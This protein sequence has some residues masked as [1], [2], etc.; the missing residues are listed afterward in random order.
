MIKTVFIGTVESSY[1]ALEEMIKKD[2][3]IEAVFTKKNNSFNSDHRSLEPLA[4]KNDIKTYFIDNINDKI[5]IKILKKIEPDF[6]FVIG[7]SQII[8][9][10]ILEIPKYGCIGFH[11]SLLPKNRGRAVIPWAILSEWEKTGVTLFYLDA[12]MDSGDIII[13]KEI[14]IDERET[15]STLYEKVIDSLKCLIKNNINK[16]LNNKIER[17]TQNEGNATYCCKRTPKDGYIDWSKSV[18]EIDRLI[19]ATTKPY[20]GAFTYYNGEKLIIWNSEIIKDNKYI[21][22]NG[23]IVKVLKNKGVLVKTKNGLLL[24]KDITYDNRNI[25]ADELFEYSGEQF[26]SLSDLLLYK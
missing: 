16:I 2:V 19:R 4:A 8:K 9:K 7:I 12:N 26:E 17:I 14:E 11:P 24:I 15:A 6:I 21:A 22:K 23:Q 18:S 13:Q 20:P 10:E 5:N 25:T 1:T 3:E